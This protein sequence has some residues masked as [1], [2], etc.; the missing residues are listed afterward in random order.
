MPNKTNRTRLLEVF[1]VLALAAM[2]CNLPSQRNAVPPTV[3]PLSPQE[4]EQFEE[5]L[6][7]TLTNTEPGREVSVTIQE[8]QLSS[9][10]AAQLADQDEPVISNPR[11][12]MTS[13]R[14]EIIAQVKQG[15]TVE[16]KSVVV[17][18]VDSNGKPRL[19]VESVTLGSLPVPE[20][21]VSQMQG[22]VDN[23]LDDYLASADTSFRITKIDITEGQ[24]VVSGM[25][26]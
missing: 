7:A 22:V 8:G 14:M 12:R 19:L 3:V 24:T 18:S 2:A 17:P 4:A 23:I 9:Y 6:Q 25:S 11:V 13:G 10:L 21:L 15:I 1:I 16:A 26:E 20:S 5:N